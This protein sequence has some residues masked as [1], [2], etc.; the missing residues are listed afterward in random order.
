MAKTLRNHKAQFPKLSIFA[1]I[2]Q[3]FIII[4][5]QMLKIDSNSGIEDQQRKGLKPYLC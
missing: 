4:A 1:G 3:Y 5:F 2:N